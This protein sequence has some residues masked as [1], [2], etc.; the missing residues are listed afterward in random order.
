[1]DIL[2][3]KKCDNSYIA[4]NEKYLR[5]CS[6]PAKTIFNFLIDDLNDINAI[7]I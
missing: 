6:D 1:M 3:P 4:G 2:K 5:I 7:S